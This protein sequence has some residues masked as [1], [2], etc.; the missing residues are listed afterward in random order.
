MVIISKAII[1]EFSSRHVDSEGPLQSWYELTVDADWKNFNQMK[2]T[3]K[4]PLPEIPL[5]L[6]LQAGDEW[7]PL[8]MPIFDTF[9]HPMI[10]TYKRKLKLTKSQE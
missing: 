2:N 5:H 1:R 9:V 10:R 7:Q 4:T 8:T 3:F 6:G